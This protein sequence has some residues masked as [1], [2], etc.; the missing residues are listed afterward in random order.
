LPDVEHALWHGGYADVFRRHAGNFRP[1]ATPR[2]VISRAVTRASKPLLAIRVIEA[3]LQEG[4][5]GVPPALAQA[6]EA[7]VALARRSGR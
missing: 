1:H 3:A 7:V 4:S 2:A 5:P 6:I